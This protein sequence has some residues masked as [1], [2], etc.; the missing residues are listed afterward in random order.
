MSLL[1][2]AAG[3]NHFLNPLFYIGIMPAWL[4]YHKMLMIVSGIFEILFGVLLLFSFSRRFAAWG[5]ILLLVAVFP[6]NI[7]MMLNYYRNDHPLLWVAI[8]RLPMQI[9]LII[10]AYQFAKKETNYN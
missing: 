9:G 10:W 4:P 2:I 5:I 1:Y 8:V 3:I 7:Q 6:A